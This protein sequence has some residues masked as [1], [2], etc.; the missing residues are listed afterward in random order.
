MCGIYVCVIAHF[1][2]LLWI[3]TTF[4]QSFISCVQL[5]QLL[6]KRMFFILVL[7]VQSYGGLNYLLPICV[8]HISVILS[9]VDYIKSAKTA[10]QL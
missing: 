7:A 2:Q 9:N 6:S 1:Y 10:L 8:Q 4:T 5:S 3:F